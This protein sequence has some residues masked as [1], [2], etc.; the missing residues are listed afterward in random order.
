VAT[1]TVLAAA[2]GC[3]PSGDLEAS[4]QAESQTTGDEAAVGE[5]S[6]RERAEDGESTTTDA[7]AEVADAP[8]SE[9]A[10]DPASPDAGTASGSDASASG[11]AAAPVATAPPTAAGT[12]LVTPQILLLIA[13]LEE[14]L[15]SLE[16]FRG[17]LARVR[18]E[19]AL[20]RD[21]T[22]PPRA[23]VS[24][25]RDEIVAAVREGDTTISSDVRDYRGY[26]DDLCGRYERWVEPNEVLRTR[27]ASFL[28]HI[29]RIEGWMQDI[30][31]CIDPG[32]YDHRCENA[33]GPPT[34]NGAEE[35]R[36]V[37]RVL[38][39]L[40]ALL[41]GVPDDRR[42]PCNDPVFDRIDRMRWTLSVARAQMPGLSTTARNLC[43]TIGVRPEDLRTL[44]TRITDEV[45]RDEAMVNQMSTSR[46]GSLRQMRATYGLPVE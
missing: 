2:S 32:P 17:M 16:R 26:L 7:S 21:P 19:A 37:R 11:G 28:E 46:R 38:D 5:A 6:G 8:A 39:E 34:G 44:V 27:L 22:I 45:A 29:D 12:P 14:E 20:S 42:F 25:L 31:R 41:E 4:E 36:R 24:G 9:G 43:E 23:C 1:A 40:R 35:A 13:N 30:L 3:G 10:V 15:R 33:Y 18:T